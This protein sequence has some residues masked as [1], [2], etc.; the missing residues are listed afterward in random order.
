MFMNRGAVFTDRKFYRYVL[1]RIWDE[2][3]QCVTF[4][5]LN[6][7]TANELRD[8]PTVNKMM[9]FAARWNGGGIYV[10][11]LFAVVSSNPAIISEA[12]DPVGPENDRYIK[13]YAAKSGIT[14]AAWGDIALLNGRDI[15]VIQMVPGLKCLGKTKSGHPLHPLYVPWGTAPVDLGIIVAS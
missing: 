5:A 14:V 4:I 15:D 10:V 7:S 12:R 11:N 3:K 8:D 13:E 6:P 2:R 1:W 9:G